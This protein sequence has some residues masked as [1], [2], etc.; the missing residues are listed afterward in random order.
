V[1][2]SP[3]SKYR[4]TPPASDTLLIV[5]TAAGDHTVRVLTSDLGA[6]CEQRL[7]SGHTA[8]ITA[9]AFDADGGVLASAS[10]DATARL[11]AADSGEPLRVLSRPGS[12]VGVAWHRAL[13]GQLCTGERSGLVAFHAVQVAH[14][15]M[16]VQTL[17]ARPVSAVDWC[18]ANP[19]LVGALGDGTWFVLFSLVTGSGLFKFSRAAP[20]YFAVAG[21]TELHLCVM[22]VRRWAQ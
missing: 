21:K 12:V 5:A 8:T 13:A 7:L 14:P 10:D 4:T 11:W 17:N 3:Q 18:P 6:Q 9:L 2:W 19:R 15:L 1:C 20:Q 16:S 22:G